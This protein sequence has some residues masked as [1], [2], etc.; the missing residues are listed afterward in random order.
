[1][2]NLQI[3]NNRYVIATQDRELQDYLRKK[4]GQPIMYLHKKTPVLEQPSELSRKTVE[5]KLNESFKF[6][7]ADEKKLGKIS[8]LNFEFYLESWCISLFL[9]MWYIFSTFFNTATLKKSEGLPVEEDTKPILKKKKKKQPNPL[10]CKKKKQ[11]KVV[12]ASDG[13]K[14]SNIETIQNKTIEKK[15]RKRVKLPSHIKEILQTQ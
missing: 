1:M 2:T 5:F 8:P 4:P 7:T 3:K 13:S 6:G 9:N 11:K 14:K 10:S 12:N 15:K